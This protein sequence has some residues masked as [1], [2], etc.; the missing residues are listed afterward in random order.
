MAKI[1]AA[2]APLSVRL[3]IT[4]TDFHLLVQGATDAHAVTQ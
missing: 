1:K 2:V 3:P 4:A